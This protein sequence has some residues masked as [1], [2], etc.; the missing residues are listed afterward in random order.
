M[1]FVHVAK[2]EPG[3]HSVRPPVLLGVHRGL[4]PDKPGVSTVPATCHGA[5]DR[6]LVPVRMRL[7]DG[8]GLP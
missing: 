3:G 1:L 4:V 5:I 7:T 8:A 2:G 6:V